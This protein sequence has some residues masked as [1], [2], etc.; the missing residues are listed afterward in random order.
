[1]VYRS[2]VNG[3]LR[4]KDVGQKVTLIG[5][6]QRKRNLGSLMFIDLRDRSGIVQLMIKDPTKVPDVKH[7]YLIQ[8][9][10]IVTKKAVANTSL[11]T[12]EIEVEV[13]T[14]KVLNEADVLPLIVDDVTDAGEDIRLQYRYLD[15]R[16]R[17][18]QDILITRSKIMQAFHVFFAKHD[19]TNIETPLLTLST[20]G[21]ARD[22]LVP[23]RLTPGSFY[24][25]PQSPQIYKQ[26]LMIGGLERYYQI[27]RCF[28]DED[29]RADRQPDFTQIDV[30][31]SFLTQDEFLSFMEEAI[32]EVFKTVKGINLPHPF[33]RLSYETAMALYG[34][35]K[36]DLRFD[37]PLS[38]IPL[39]LKQAYEKAGFES[40]NIKGLKLPNAGGTLS[41]KVL[42]EWVTFVKPF[43]IKGLVTFKLEQGQLQSSFLKFVAPESVQ[44]L[45]R[46]LD[47]KVGDVYLVASHD[48]LTVLNTAM[49]ILRTKAA[50]LLNII[51]EKKMAI[52]WVTDFP[53]FDTNEEGQL[54][55][56]H[57]PFTRPQ[58]QHLSILKTQPRKVLAQAY[59]LVINGYE[60][61][62]GS[63]RIYDKEVQKQIFSILGMTEEAIQK[64]FGWFIQAFNYG[65]PPH[66]GIAFGL[67][68]L[69]MILTGTDNIKDVIAFPKN[70]KMVGLLEGTPNTVETKQ[71]DELS[72]QVKEKK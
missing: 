41:R 40:S 42:D 7:E 66:G 63:M 55:A 2:H 32:R 13:T 5:W 18:M 39:I 58:D 52:A 12:G 15:L 24:A 72:I 23:S 70:L 21:G 35:D 46:L 10:G 25:L 50:K 44:E 43:G 36:P 22:F 16:R 19:F 67:D 17:P 1:M 31:A 64:K 61:G 69:T 54:V 37:L 27:A 34:T 9:Q 30:E 8:I 57:H 71:I 65:T 11:A 62:G 68:R 45:S 29:L 20:P 4:L 59:D 6:V 48:D 60:A 26:L 56:A 3:I 51:D 49:G 33:P 28:R 38:T 47:L 53:L 14:F